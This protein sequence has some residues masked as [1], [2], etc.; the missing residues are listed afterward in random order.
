MA[1][2]LGFLFVLLLFLSAQ[3]ASQ[4]ACVELC[5]NS[6]WMGSLRDFSSKSLLKGGPV[7]LRLLRTFCGWVLNISR[8]RDS[9]TSHGT[10]SQCLRALMVK[11]FSQHQKPMLQL[12]P[13]A[14]RLG[15]FFLYAYCNSIIEKL[16]PCGIL[17]SSGSTGDI[18]QDRTMVTLLMA[19]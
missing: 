16:W 2:V 18:S 10:F 13:T 19:N 17:M 6:G 3:G 11:S 7:Q 4:S 1:R 5:S 15:L 8:V 14:F 9:R 12:V